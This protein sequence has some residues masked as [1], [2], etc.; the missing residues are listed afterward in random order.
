VSAH[1]C[2]TRLACLL[3]L[4]AHD[5][6]T[7]GSLY[8]LT[9]LAD[10][11]PSGCSKGSA[12]LCP[13][14]GAEK[15]P[16]RNLLMVFW[17]LL[18]DR[19]HGGVCVCKNPRLC[20]RAK[21]APGRLHA[22][23]CT[24]LLQLSQ[25]RS[26]GDWVVCVCVVLGGSA[27]VFFLGWGVCCPRLLHAPC[28]A[29]PS[30]DIARWV[31]CCM[32]ARRLGALWV[33]GNGNNAHTRTPAMHIHTLGLDC[34]CLP[35]AWL[36]G[37]RGWRG[38]GCC[39]CALCILRPWLLPSPL[40]HA[41]LL[42]STGERAEVAVFRVLCLCTSPLVRTDTTHRPVLPA[43][44]HQPTSRPGLSRRCRHNDQAGTGAGPSSRPALCTLLALHAC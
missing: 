38:W 44:A 30:A 14:Q 21:K 32:L 41:Q 17:F 42:Q 7:A 40:L 9:V 39:C 13:R 28:G 35:V 23:W 27:S 1:R 16:R 12:A 36:A 18:E 20:L 19:V 31:F 25:L 29:Q 34:W 6:L 22:A 33:K 8:A 2:A 5:T 24:R 37:I 10:G 26:V 43:A 3:L 15:A 4:P 11:L